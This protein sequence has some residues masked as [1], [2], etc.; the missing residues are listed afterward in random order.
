MK[1]VLRGAALAAAGL[2]LSGVSPL[3][4][5]AA[6]AP[7]A[8]GTTGRKKTQRQKGQI[9]QEHASHSQDPVPQNSKPRRDL[10]ARKS[11]PEDPPR[12]CRRNGAALAEPCHEGRILA[13]SPVVGSPLGA[14]LMIFGDRMRPPTHPRQFQSVI[15]GQRCATS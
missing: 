11:G 4:T 5:R 2:L 15:G 10:N 7:P 6:A 14:H 8:Y 12:T 13:L 1:K 9:A 3:G